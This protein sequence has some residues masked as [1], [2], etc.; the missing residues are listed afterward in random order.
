[1]QSKGISFLGSRVR[2]PFRLICFPYAG[3]DAVTIFRN[4]PQTLPP[5]IQVCPVLM[6]GRGVRSA[7]QPFTNIL[8]AAR[9]LGTELRPH[10]DRPFAFFGHSMGAVLSFE[11]A[12][13][14]KMNGSPEPLHL[15]V[16]GARAPHLPDRHSRTYDLPEAEFLWELQR[17]NGTPAEVLQNPELMNLLLPV[18]R[19]DFE[20]C[21]TYVYNCGC[22]LNCPVTAFGGLQDVVTHDEL[23]SWRKQS[24]GA[25]RMH[26]FPGD[27][28][29]INSQQQN[30][31]K[32]LSA[33]L[34]ECFQ[35]RRA[36]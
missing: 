11:V 13:L 29:F 35:N 14:L 1:L 24:S 10:L 22:T 34:A 27:H 26:T 25:F 4:W 36:A 31:L 23:D 6:P 7:E 3:G 17:L 28:F 32:I 9:A 18:L 12:R 33:G 16:S 30:I 20:A 19:A 8:S 2:A 5:N 15:F 21:Q